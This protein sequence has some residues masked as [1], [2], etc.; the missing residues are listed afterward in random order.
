MRRRVVRVQRREDE[1]AGE[2]GLDRDLGGLD[3]ADL[4]DH[5]HVGVRAEDRAERRGEREAGANVDLDLVHAREAVLDRVLDRDDVD[6][7]PADLGEAAVE[8]RRLARAGRPGDEQRAR[9]EADDLLELG[10]HRIREP[11]LAHR[12]RAARLVE[13]AHHDLLALDRRERRHADVEHAADRRRGQRDTAVLRLAALGDVELRE[14][15]QARRDPRRHALGNALHLPQHAVDP[16]PDHERVLV[17]L[18]VDVRGVLLGRLEDHGVHEPD[19]RA[20]GDAV[21]G[22]EVVGLLVRCRGLLGLDGDGADGLGRADETLE[23]RD[24]VDA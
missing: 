8:R 21:V 17:R 1:V 22:L 12:R 23:L 16:E 6:L 24:D 13:E 9:R 5:H 20:V 14:H 19:E 10:A 18:E 15:L 4:A 3:V 2:R 7:G 11:E